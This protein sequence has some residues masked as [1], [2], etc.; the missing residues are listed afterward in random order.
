[1][2]KNY[3]LRGPPHTGTRRHAGTGFDSIH[4]R[5]CPILSHSTFRDRKHAQL[6]ATSPSVC[7]GIAGLANT[8]RTPFKQAAKGLRLIAAGAIDTRAR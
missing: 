1:M 6:V 5:L 3:R 4:Y 8:H 2:E 7:E